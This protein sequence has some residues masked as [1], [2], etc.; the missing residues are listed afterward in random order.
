MMSTHDLLVFIRRLVGSAPTTVITGYATHVRPT[1][2]MGL[3]TTMDPV[4]P[5]AGEAIHVWGHGR[6]LGRLESAGPSRSQCRPNH[7]PMRCVPGELATHH[8]QVFT[9]LQCEQMAN[10]LAE[11]CCILSNPS[12]QARGRDMDQDLR[13]FW[14]QHQRA[15]AVHAERLRDRY[16]RGLDLATRD[17]EEA[18]YAPIPGDHRH[19]AESAL[20]WTATDVAAVHITATSTRGTRTFT[21]GAWAT[22]GAVYTPKSPGTDGGVP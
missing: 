7:M 10:S 13:S 5:H 3:Y 14:R 15:T 12:R 2:I 22:G 17:V 1:H 6:Y 18:R 4:R 20:T 11:A 19:E 9:V 16:L 8:G 21:R